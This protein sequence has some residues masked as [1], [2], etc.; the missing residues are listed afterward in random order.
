MRI[1]E[2]KAFLFS[3]LNDEAKEKAH[4][5]FLNSERDHYW[6]DDDLESLKQGLIHFG[7]ELSD[8]SIDYYCATNAHLKIRSNYSEN[9]EEI[10]SV[11]LW[12]YLHNNDLLRYWCKYENKVRN[13]LDGNSPFTGYCMDEDFLDPIKSFIKHPTNITFQELMEACAYQV[14]KAIEADYEYQCSFEYFAEE[15]ETN[16]YEFEEDG[17]RI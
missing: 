3:E 5:N 17:N 12:K 13:L 2:T 14:M 15:A 16:G 6:V 8:W 1:I 11:R 9:E 4:E 10:N 7:F